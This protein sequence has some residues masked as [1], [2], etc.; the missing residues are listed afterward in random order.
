M[1]MK[2]RLDEIGLKLNKLKRN[3]ILN[4]NLAML[5][6]ANAIERKDDSSDLDMERLKS[7]DKLIL[8]LSEFI[9][10]VK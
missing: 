4:L 5:D 7:L 3:E 8:Q 2:K 10:N 9:S 6:I 1:K